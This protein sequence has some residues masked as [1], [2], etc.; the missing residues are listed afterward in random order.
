MPKG[1][2]LTEEERLRRRREIFDASVHLF[3]EK[4]F[5][6]TSMREVAEAAGIGKSSLYDYF[7]SKDDIL[8]SYFEYAIEGIAQKANEIIRQDH[9][10][11]EKLKNIMRM[12]LEYLVRNRQLFLR[13]TL[14]AQNLSPQ[15]QEQLQMLRHSYQDMIRSLIVEG[16]QS[17][18]LRPVNPLLAARN[19]FSLL[20][21]TAYTSRPTGS[22]EEML[23]DAMEIFFNGVLT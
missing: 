19:V 13:F 3:I 9:S 7:Q 20:S 6:Q 5:Y 8:I 21:Q 15:S 11:T 22:P 2:P 17:G 14:E 10:V 18:E 12:H 16:I 23:N 4:G 1:L